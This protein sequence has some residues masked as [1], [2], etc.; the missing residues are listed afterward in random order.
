MAS[1][2]PGKPGGRRR[3]REVEDRTVVIVQH[4][5][6]AEVQMLLEPGVAIEPP[7]RVPGEDEVA[8]PP[9]SQCVEGADR[10]VGVARDL[11][12]CPGPLETPALSLTVVDGGRIPLGE[13]HE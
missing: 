1:M 2:R 11:P 6:V 10:L 13:H 5:P 7:A 9:R 12:W 3:V 8:G 4:P